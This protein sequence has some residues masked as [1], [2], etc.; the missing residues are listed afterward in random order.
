MGLALAATDARARRLLEVASDVTGVD[1]P[2]ALERGGRALSRTEVIQPVLVAVGLGF[3]HA[4]TEREGPP[5]VVLGH[6]LGELTC[7]SAVSVRC[8]SGAALASAWAGPASE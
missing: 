2:R 4:W 3:A 6:S 7:A 1:V 8:A 5:D